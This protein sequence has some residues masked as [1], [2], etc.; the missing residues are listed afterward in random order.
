M[1][2]NTYRVIVRGRIVA[3]Y[4][5]LDQALRHLGFYTPGVDVYVEYTTGITTR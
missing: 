3:E 5:T 2:A 1:S 4:P